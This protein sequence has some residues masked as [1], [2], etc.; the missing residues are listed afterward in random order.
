MEETVAIPCTGSFLAWFS[1]DTGSDE[2]LAETGKR[3][4]PVCKMQARAKPEKIQGHCVPN[5]KALLPS[6][7][8][9]EI[10]RDS[11]QG[12]GNRSLPAKNQGGKWGIWGFWRLGGFSK[13]L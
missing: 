3:L 8:H 6:P 2:G 10:K 4:H 9:F 5:A 1:L 12:R 13:S 7:I 11:L